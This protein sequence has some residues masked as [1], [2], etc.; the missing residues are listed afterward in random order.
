MTVSCCCVIATQFNLHRFGIMANARWKLRQLARKTLSRDDN[1]NRAISH[2]YLRVLLEHFDKYTGELNFLMDL[3]DRGGTITCLHCWIEVLAANS[4]GQS[5]GLN[6]F[7]VRSCLSILIPGLTTCTALLT[8]PHCHTRTPRP[9][10]QR[11]FTC[12][13]IAAT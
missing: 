11:H 1:D 8:G 7:W 4:E 13:R 2:Q 6:A 10:I 9:C 12:R 3:E 5:E